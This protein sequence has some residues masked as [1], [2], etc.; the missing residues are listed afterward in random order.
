VTVIL[1]PADHVTGIKLLQHHIIQTVIEVSTFGAQSISPV[2]LA[3]PVVI[4][5]VVVVAAVRH[6]CYWS[7]HPCTRTIADPPVFPFSQSHSGAAN[8]RSRSTRNVHFGYAA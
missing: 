5:V 1:S 2:D 6:F 8:A 7:T 3:R 4:V